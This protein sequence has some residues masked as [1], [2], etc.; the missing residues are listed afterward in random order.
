[1]G[2]TFEV[3]KDGEKYISLTEHSIK[4]VLFDS[5]KETELS[6]RLHTITRDLV[7]EGLINTDLMNE[8][9]KQL[10]DDHGDPLV[11]EDGEPQYALR[12]IDSVRQLANWAII[13]EYC[14]CYCDVCIQLRDARGEFVNED[15]FECMFVEY[16]KESFD[17]DHGNGYFTIHMREREIV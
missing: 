9:P 3:C 1:M 12:E 15:E 6:P 7:I 4:N 8:A 17:I 11:D 5:D 16:Y 14:K 2:V 10:L 13:P